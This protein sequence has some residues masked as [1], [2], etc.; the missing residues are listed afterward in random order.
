MF[1]VAKTV[2]ATLLLETPP[3]VTTTLPVLA[4]FGTGTTIE[5]SLQLVGEAIVPLKLT[6]LVP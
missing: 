1:G 5:V 3:V 4:P 2:N 6:V